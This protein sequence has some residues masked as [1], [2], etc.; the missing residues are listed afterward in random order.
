MKSIFST[1]LTAIA[2]LV[3]LAIPVW[4]G[5]QEKLDH[6]KQQRYQLIDLGTFGGSSSYF[7]G[8][9]AHALNKHGVAAGGA[10][11]PTPD[12]YAPNC[13][14]PECLIGHTFVFED[15]QTIDLG[16]LP[17]TNNSA[18]NDINAKGV[19]AGISENGMIDPITG[20]PETIAVVW[21]NGQ[22]IDLGTFG[23]N[24]SYANAINDRGQVAGFA[25]NTTP[26]SFGFAALCMNPPF[27]QQQQAFIWRDG[28]MQN[29]GTLGGPDSCALWVNQKGQAAGH[30]LTNAIINPVTGFPTVDPFLWDH[31]SMRDLGGLG[32]TFSLASWLNDRGQ[33]VGLSNL[34]G[35]LTSHPFLWTEPGPMQDLGTLGGSNGVAN[36]I[37]GDGEVV[38]K[39]DLPGS[40]THDAF[41]SKDGVIA[42]LG[43][44]DGDPCSNALAIN[45]SGQIVGGSSDCSNFLHA[46]LWEDGGPMIDLNAFVPAGSNLTLTEATF[47]N[48]RGEISVQAVLPNGDSRAVLLVPCGHGNHSEGC[49]DDS[50]GRVAVPQTSAEERNTSRRTVPPFHIRRGDREQMLGR[51]D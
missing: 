5:A 4:L 9:G 6:N 31:G 44:Q 48:D 27:G 35:D 18:P 29:L 47:I 13:F 12:P 41:L 24:F 36:S 46:F 33:V 14:N 28:V 23:G 34:N 38:G 8:V 1:L 43:T 42:D 37:N 51:R 15:G 10:D 19:V 7:V 32:G 3:A 26:D 21:K 22:I 50:L 30:S 11:T 49:Q 40:Q 16:S 20:L 2:L 17:G 39:A 45:A 25:L